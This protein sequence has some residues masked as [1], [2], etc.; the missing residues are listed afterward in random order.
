MLG[1]QHN[2]YFIGLCWGFALGVKQILCFA[3]GVTQILAF[4]DTNLLVYPTQSFVL[5]V[6]SNANPQR[7]KI[8]VAVEYRLNYQVEDITIFLMHCS[9]LI[10]Y[11]KELLV[12]HESNTFFQG[13][14][15]ILMALQIL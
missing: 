13:L 15:P 14:P 6:L 1:T 3:L 8:C 5:G 11:R 2:L 7:E 9:I 4:L 12:M 10:R